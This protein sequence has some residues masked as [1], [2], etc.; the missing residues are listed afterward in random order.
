[1]RGTKQIR[2]MGILSKK[3]G[4]IKWWRRWREQNLLECAMSKIEVS[5]WEARSIRCFFGCSWRS[6]EPEWWIPFFFFGFSVHVNLLSSFS[7]HIFK[8]GDKWRAW[9]LN[10]WRV[11][12]EDELWEV[13]FLLWCFFS[14]LVVSEKWLL[15]ES[16]EK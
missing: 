1:M 15:K 10:R 2:K 16:D 3:K 9:W 8:L 11:W 6:V 4:G 12:R 14:F 13:I 5:W 7:V